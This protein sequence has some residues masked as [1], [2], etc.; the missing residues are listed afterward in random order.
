M[1][2]FLIIQVKKQFNILSDLIDVLLCI[3]SGNI[4]KLLI[5]QQSPLIPKVML[6]ERM[7]LQVRLCYRDQI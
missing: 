7:N 5:F 3:L 6:K 2:F 1:R 4:V